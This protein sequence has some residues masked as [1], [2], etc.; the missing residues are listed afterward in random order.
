MTPTIPTKPSGR[1]AG[2]W[3]PTRPRPSARAG[4]C[5]PA[6]PATP[7]A[8]TTTTCRPTGS[9]AAP[10]RWP[11]RAPGASWI[12]FPALVNQ[13]GA[14]AGR[15]VSGL[16]LLEGYAPPSSSLGDLR[17]A[18]GS[19]DACRVRG[20]VHFQGHAGRVL[21][22]AGR[23]TGLPE[24][25]RMCVRL[26]RRAVYLGTP[27]AD[28]RCPADAIGA[29]AGDPGRSRRPGACS[30]AGQQR[31]RHSGTGRTGGRRKPS[32]ASAST[33]ARH[34]RRGRCRP[35]PPR[36]TGRSASTSAAPTAPAPSPT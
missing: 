35:G 16:Q 23:S 17:P 32:P 13:P 21:L 31:R 10:S 19:R 24:H 6:S 22:P 4:R 5:S 26:D 27:A 28:Q 34:P 15:I 11:A 36:P 7:P 25:P 18:R 8:P 14:V 1:R 20:R 12:W 3:S 33:P 9:R 2:G 29:A 30:C